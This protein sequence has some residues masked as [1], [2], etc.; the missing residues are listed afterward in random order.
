MK[1]KWFWK[2]G[3]G[4]CCW[5]SFHI[6]QKKRDVMHVACQSCTLLPALC[7][8]VEGWESHALK[9]PLWFTRSSCPDKSM[10]YIVLTI[11]CTIH[12]YCGLPLDTC[13]QWTVHVMHACLW[14][15]LSTVSGYGIGLRWSSIMAIRSTLTK[16]HSTTQRHLWEHH[17][18]NIYRTIKGR[19]T[20]DT[21]H[22]HGWHI[23]VG[24]LPTVLSP[25]NHHINA[26]SHITFASLESFYWTKTNWSANKANKA[27]HIK[28][29]LYLKYPHLVKNTG[30]SSEETPKMHTL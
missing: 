28:P 1:L 22:A 3:T 19:R 4:A 6:K 15:T 14:S 21:G 29:V 13:G 10:C 30:H 24:C 7:S 8:Q 5:W 16:G 18:L 26:S 27:H 23:M 25:S 20:M 17:H 2:L 11:V 9:P 12:C